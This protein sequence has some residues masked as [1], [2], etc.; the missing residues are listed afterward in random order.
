MDKFK[1]NQLK[2]IARHKWTNP[3]AL[4]AT[5]AVFAFLVAI[6]GFVLLSA[7]ISLVLVLFPKL[8]EI[9]FYAT[10]CIATVILQLYILLI[11]CFFCKL[12]KVKLFSGADL[13]FKFDFSVCLPALA[14]SV[15][16]YLLISPAHMQFAT[17][18][19]E[20][21]IALFGSGTTL[22]EMQQTFTE[23][24]AVIIFAFVVTPLLPAI[25]EEALFRGVIMSGLREFGSLFAIFISGLL[26]ALMHGNFSQMILQFILGCEMAFVVLITGNYFAS[27]IM[28]FCNNLI[29]IIY[30][31]A[32]EFF[33]MVSP[34]LSYALEAILL[35]VGVA[36]ISFAIIYYVKLSAYKKNEGHN[37]KKFAFYKP[38]KKS[39]CC[40]LQSGL[41]Y[42][43]CFAVEPNIVAKSNNKG[44][45]FFAGGKFNKFNGRSNKVLFW[46]IFSISLFIAVGLIFF[47]FIMVG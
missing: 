10:N 13:G 1:K 34:T 30:A 6:I 31:I 11:A 5:S 18:I 39:P 42:E 19:E 29:A 20:I 24:L 2:N 21:K 14:L 27:V 3:N 8:Q 25:C 43:Y 40:L 37:K 41:P 16:T 46:V 7:L 26:F 15:G 33:A 9:G 17:Y 22:P 35:L 28:H 47:D 44:F 4:S 38:I 32:I 12:N 45:L 23:I 36:L